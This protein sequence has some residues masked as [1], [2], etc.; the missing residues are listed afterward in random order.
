MQ[1]ENRSQQGRN[2]KSL[3]RA[4]D[5]YEYQVWSWNNFE[6]DQVTPSNTLAQTKTEHKIASDAAVTDSATKHWHDVAE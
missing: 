1:T 4:L 5:R 6:V 2:N 3:C